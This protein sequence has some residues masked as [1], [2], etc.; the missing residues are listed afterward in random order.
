MDSTRL[1][2]KQNKVHFIGQI[3]VEVYYFSTTGLYGR[4]AG[5]QK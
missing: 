1:H 5:R 4:L 2:L 3:K